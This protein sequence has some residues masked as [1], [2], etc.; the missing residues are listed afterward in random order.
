MAI[1][2]I[3]EKIN[4]ERAKFLLS[5]SDKERE[6]LI[7]TDT[8]EEDNQGEKFYDKKTY[9]DLVVKYLKKQLA[10][11]C[12]LEIEYDYSKNMR[13]NGRL[14][15]QQFSLQSMKKNL[16]G[17]LVGSDDGT[18]YYKD[19]DI[20]NCH[21][22][23]LAW[24]MLN[25]GIIEDDD[26]FKQE[27][28]FLYDYTR[29]VK[30]RNDF[31][32][33]AKCTK[34]DIV[35]MLNSSFNTE[36]FTQY[37]VGIDREFKRIQKIVYDFT[38]D[39]LKEYEHFKGSEQKPNKRGSFINKIMCIFENRFINIVKEEYEEKYPFRQVV[40][41]LIFDGMH[42]TSE[43]DNQVDV[44]NKFTDEQ[45]IEWAIKD[46]DTSIQESELYKNRD[47]DSISNIKSKDY[48]TVKTEFEKNHFMI[49]Y[50]LMFVKETTIAG[51]PVIHTYNQTD[52]K[53]VTRR[54]KF[55][56][57][58]MEEV[59]IFEKW[60]GDDDTRFYK[61]LD[62]I[63]TLNVNDEI[64]NTFQGFHYSNYKE[65]GF[66]QTDSLINLFKK[67]IS[68]LV[69]HNDVS[70]DYCFKYFAHMFQFPDKRPNVALVF[71]S[72]QG[73]GKDS[74]LDCISKLIGNENLYRTSKPDDIF[75]Q[76]NAALKNKLL[77]QL[78]ELEG[79]DGFANKD[80]L[81]DLIT[82]NET[83]INEKNRQQYNQSNYLRII[84]C[85]NRLNSVEI[86]SGDRRFVVFE[87]DRRKPTRQHF[88][89][90]HNAMNDDNALYSLYE[91]LMNYD[92]GK[93]PLDDCRPITTAYK[94]MR[95]NNTHPFFI[96]LKETLS[97]YKNLIEHKTHKT[98]KLV[99]VS[100]SV[101]FSEYKTHMD[102]SHQN[103]YNFNQ[104]KNMKDLLTSLKVLHKPKSKI[105]GTVV[106]AYWFDIPTVLEY[107]NEIVQEEEDSEEFFEDDFE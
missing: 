66:T 42:I 44:I 5:L 30:H 23:V 106:S 100:S 99:V 10:N 41:T 1:H 53:G 105:N 64:Y 14:F 25:S 79:K 48:K 24:I 26:N 62:F 98:S 52:F 87:A 58:K 96:W 107:L 20:V 59:S 39:I 31:L 15:S 11:D 74:I 43:L 16:R 81:K 9:L 92:V 2:T 69:D 49:E 28:P 37:A 54:I 32:E 88:S 70:I 80:K 90:F 33:K 12:E 68:T 57:Q 36:I 18:Y 89:D 84:I 47:V 50:P 29:S 101:L 21:P 17:F 63:P 27:Y 3:S 67:T 56:N 83:N 71:K 35:I 77:L 104:K 78:N 86:P 8:N 94:N 76:F 19:Y 97:D 95:D 82:Q 60:L 72:E 45:G 93:T 34:N 38:P 4:V 22:T 73:Y 102:D 75:G 55:N 46:F 6:T 13:T 65:V 51:K 61:K 40:S 7:W 85:T 91:Y 103:M